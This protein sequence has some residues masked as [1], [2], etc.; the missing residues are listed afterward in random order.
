MTI[1]RLNWSFCFFWGGWGV[2]FGYG[3]DFGSGQRR[4]KITTAIFQ[5]TLR[6]QDACNRIIVIVRHVPIYEDRFVLVVAFTISVYPERYSVVVIDVVVWYS[7]RYYWILGNPPT[8]S[9]LV[10]LRQATCCVHRYHYEQDRIYTCDVDWER[11][12][13]FWFMRFLIKNNP[14]YFL[15]LW[16]L[17]WRGNREHQVATRLLFTIGNEVVAKVS[18]HALEVAVDQLFLKGRPHHCVEDLE[19]I[20]RRCVNRCVATY[21]QVSYLIRGIDRNNWRRYLSTVDDEVAEIRIR[22]RRRFS[23]L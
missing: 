16:L 15:L 7:W 10:W 9:R 20:C 13:G 22:R 23:Q 17:L 18:Q 2:Y 6:G 4:G 8:S 14:L 3:L 21:V 11:P 5:P 19:K 1:S 12:W